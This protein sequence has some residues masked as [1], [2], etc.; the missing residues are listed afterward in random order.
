MTVMS[1]MAH[2]IQGVK[3]NK[4]SGLHLRVT[5]CAVGKI[6]GPLSVIAREEL[7]CLPKLVF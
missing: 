7:L 2:C 1:Y 6:H 4:G 3:Y 5:D